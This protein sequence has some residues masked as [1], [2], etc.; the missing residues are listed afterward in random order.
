MPLV[1]PDEGHVR[2]PAPKLTGA[3]N[4]YYSVD[5]TR[6]TSDRDAYTAECNDIIEA[7]GMTFAE[8]EA[9]KALWRHAIVRQGRGKPGSTALYEAEKVEFFGRRLVAL[10]R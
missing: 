2:I 6:P 7:L 5:V 8:G 1:E 3:S 4:S 10:A 9:F